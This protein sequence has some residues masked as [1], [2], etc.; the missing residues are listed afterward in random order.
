MM[1]TKTV[2]H[3]P[4]IAQIFDGAYIESL[5]EGN[6]NNEQADLLTSAVS[7]AVLTSSAVNPSRVSEV[8]VVKLDRDIIVRRRGVNPH[9]T[10]GAVVVSVEAGWVASH[11]SE[12][13]QADLKTAALIALTSQITGQKFFDD[14]RTKQQLGYICHSAAMVQERRAGLL[15]LVQSE[16]PT[17][18]VQDKM[19]VFIN[20]LEDTVSAIGKEDFDQYIGAVVADL[21]EK[22][23]NQEEEFQR[24]WAEIEK[25]RFDFERKGRLVPVVQ[26]LTQDD[27]VQFVRDHVVNAPKVITIV[28]GANEPNTPELLSDDEIR[29]FKQTAKWIESYSKPLSRDLASKM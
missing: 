4:S 15:F 20:K 8:R 11:V 5:I 18:E 13:N 14:L 9:E 6:M 3:L 19:F 7:S 12:S 2:D 24:H 29:N 23:K 17:A 16:V 10:N 25:R 1:A 21:V 22:P 26:S 28:T 27:L